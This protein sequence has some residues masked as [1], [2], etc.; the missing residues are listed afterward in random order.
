MSAL[1][2][3]NIRQLLLRRAFSSPTCL[4][5]TIYP[6]MWRDGDIGST[7]LNAALVDGGSC[8][9][10]EGQD[11]GMWE[12]LGAELGRVRLHLSSPREVIARAAMK[13]GGVLLQEDL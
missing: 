12:S 1:I 4:R 2:S 11:W 8:V 5:Q 10:H 6:Y 13:P 3:R 7:T 9:V